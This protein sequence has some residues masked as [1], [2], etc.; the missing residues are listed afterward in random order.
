MSNYKTLQMYS[1]STDKLA[2]CREHA[3]VTAILDDGLPFSMPWKLCNQTI[4]HLLSE[5]GILDQFVHSGS[6]HCDTIQCYFMK[7]QE[8]LDWDSAYAVDP[9]TRTVM[10]GLVEHKVNEWTT[11]ELSNAGLRYKLAMQE[12]RLLMVDRKL[13]LFKPVFNKSDMWG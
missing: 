7:P 13:V 1:I 12:G 8:T 4:T 6:E 5:L 11:L 3:T 2:A 10:Q 9:V